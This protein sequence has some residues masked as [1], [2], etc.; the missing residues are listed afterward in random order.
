MSSERDKGF[1][2]VRPWVERRTPSRDKFTVKTS[3][4]SPWQV[5]EYMLDVSLFS[6]HFSYKKPV[7]NEN[8]RGI[9]HTVDHFVDAVARRII[10]TLNSGDSD[11][12]SALNFAEI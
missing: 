12:V 4:L 11:F 8:Y 7:C 3:Q 2:N 9:G 10:G 5:Y 6:S 1:S